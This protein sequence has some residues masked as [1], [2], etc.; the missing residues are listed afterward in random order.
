ALARPRA[1]HNA[2]PRV[3]AA[4]RDTPAPADALDALAPVRHPQDLPPLARTQALMAHLVSHSADV[5]TLTERDTGRYAMVNPAFERIIGYASAEVLGRTAMEL[6]VWADPTDRQRLMHALEADGKASNIPATFVVRDG[7]LVSMLLTASRFRMDEREYMVLSARDITAA[8]QTRLEYQ[9]I[10]ENALIGVA[11]TRSE[12]F[13]MAN[14]RFEAMLG[15]AP[16][17]MLGQHGS[18]VWPSLAD[19]QRIGREIG[20]KLAAGESIEIEQP[21]QRKDGSTFL[22]R[23]L[24][25]AV[26]PTHPARAGTLWLAEDVTERRQFELALAR[27]RDEAEAANRA[28]SAFLANTSHE[29]RTPL[30]ALLGLA[31]LARQPEVDEIRR[32]NYI[33]QISDSAETLSLIISDILDLS[34]IEAGKMHVEQLPFRLDELLQ[35]LQQSYGALADARG[36]SMQL[37]CDPDIPDVVLGDSVRVRQ[38]LSNFLNNALKFTPRGSIVLIVRRGLANLLRFEVHDTGVGISA[39]AQAQLFMPF[40]QVDSSMNR[41]V[42]GTGLGL[43][44]CRQ[45]AQLM[46]GEVGL[47]SVPGE[48][49]LFWAELPLPDSSDEDLDISTGSEGFDPIEG[50]RVLMV[51]DNPVNMMI[52]VALLEQWGAQVEQAQ[53]GAEAI[54]AIDHAA[55]VGNPFDVVLMDVQ[56][57]GISG[58]EATRRLRLVYSMHQLPIIALTAAALLSER[59]QALAEGMNDF[60]TKP[61]DAHRLRSTLVRTLRAADAAR[62]QA[63]DDD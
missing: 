32:R 42:G 27:A 62:E 9:T 20:P 3:E 13:T 55:A 8:E 33:E 29:I 16:G 24:A 12:R 52:S 45:L 44:I 1:R 57:P 18:V 5:I 7:K 30:N 34:R 39:E 11:L 49:S 21:I 15:W 61:I 4:K 22:C 19:Y 43:S 63:S 48:G 23:L 53:N 58:H 25:K 40:S 41:N 2:I 56:M 28:K 26:N 6:G 54:D 35:S 59:E 50:A 31:R 38:I 51:E 60:L 14:P 10:L 17:S 37:R 36:L 47:E 46:G